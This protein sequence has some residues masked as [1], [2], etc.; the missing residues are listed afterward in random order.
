MF[1]VAAAAAMSS[2]PE[3]S[4]GFNPE[5]L[6]RLLA[7]QKGLGFKGG[8]AAA[9]AAAAAGAAAA[10]DEEDDGVDRKKWSIIYPAY[11]NKKYTIKQGRRV[12]LNIAVDNPTT[13]EIKIV[14]EHLH[15]PCHIEAVCLYYLFI[16]LLF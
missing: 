1:A 6:G 4:L 12:S 14:C 5:I 9:A 7:S 10:A 16:Y 2:N 8:S 13:K 11:L 15:I 3:E